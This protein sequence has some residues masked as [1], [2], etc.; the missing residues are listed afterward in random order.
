MVEKNKDQE[1]RLVNIDET[2]NCFTEEIM[3]NELTTLCNNCAKI[4]Q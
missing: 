1:F 4:V 3:Q 2:G